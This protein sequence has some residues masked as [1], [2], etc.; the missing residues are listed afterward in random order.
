VIELSRI[1]RGAARAG[2]VPG[3]CGIGPWPAASSPRVPRSAGCGAG[4]RGADLCSKQMA[5]VLF[6]TKPEC[7]R[8]QKGRENMIELSRIGM[9]FSR[10]AAPVAPDE[11]RLPSLCSAN[12]CRLL[13]PGVS[14]NRHGSRSLLEDSAVL[15]TGSREKLVTLRQR[16]NPMFVQHGSSPNRSRSRG[17]RVPSAADSRAQQ[18]D[19]H[20]WLRPEKLALGISD[21]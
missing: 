3:G 7:I 16:T 19:L 9:P 5:W 14:G 17:R 2:P 11:W 8:K 12:K 15:G 6:Q 21:A 4:R 18:S 1:H 20:S 10:A 13:R